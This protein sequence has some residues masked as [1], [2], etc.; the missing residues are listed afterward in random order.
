MD[1]LEEDW[2]ELQLYFLKKL[3]SPT[4]FQSAF[5]LFLTLDMMLGRHICLTR[6]CD[7]V[8]HKQLLEQYKELQ[9][10]LLPNE[11]LA[12]LTKYLKKGRTKVYQFRF[13]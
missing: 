4:V 12:P 1:K 13:L 9:L 6:S 10:A 2:N 11:D 8:I 7:F 3:D 5:L